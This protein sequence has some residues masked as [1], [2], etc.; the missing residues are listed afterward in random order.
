VIYAGVSLDED[1][2]DMCALIAFPSYEAFETFAEDPDF[3][4]LRELARGVVD[5]RVL[6]AYHPMPDFGTLFLG[7]A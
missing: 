7:G 2:P 4:R 3:E 1:D 5:E 6:A